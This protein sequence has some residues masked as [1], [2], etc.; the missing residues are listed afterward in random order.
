[1]DDKRV[2]EYFVV[3]GL[4]DNPVP[5]E[6]YNNDTAIKSTHKQDPIVD[7]AVIIRN[8]GEKPPKGFKCVELTPLGFPADLNHGSIRSPEVYLCYRRGRDKPPLIDIGVLYE[9]KERV[10]SG[11][12]VIHVTPG[13]RPANVNNSTSNRIYITFRRAGE[14]AA[15]DTLAVTD[16]CVILAN[17]GETPPHAY[18]QIGK[19][20][21][22]AMVGSDVYLCYKKSMAKANTLAYQPA[23]LNRYPELNYPDFPL[24]DQVSMFCLPMG[25]TIESWSSTAQHPL[26]VF[27]TFVLTDET[28]EQVY[29][30]AVTFYEEY[31]EDKLNDS[32]KEALSLKEGPTGNPYNKIPKTVHS[33]KS[34]C[35]LSRWPF[36][37]AFKKFLSYLY[38]I[39]ISGPHDVPI[40]RHIS[41][42]MHEVP[43]PSPQRPRI[44]VQLRQ[45]A[46]SLSMPEDSPLPH[47]GASF[48]TL[49]K[50][51]GP[52]DSMNV[53]LFALM[54]HKLLLHSLRPAVLTSVTEAVITMIF[55][56]K[57]QCPYIPLCPLGMSGV[58]NAP[59]PFIVGVDSRY[60]D[61]YDPPPDVTC[62]D[63]DTQTI[64]Q[65]EERKSINYKMLP[66]KPAKVL[67]NTLERLFDIVCESA[68]ATPDEVAL[69]MNMGSVDHDFKRK[70]KEIIMET[71]VQEAFLRFMAS[72]L[73]GYKHH[74]LPITAAPTVGTTDASRLFDM[75]NFLKSREK[76]NHRFFTSIMKTQTFIRFIEDRS[77]VSDNDASLAFFD[78]CAEKVD[79]NRDEPKLIELDESLRQDRTV[80][81]LPPEPTGLAEGVKYSYNGFPELNDGLF[82]QRIVPTGFKTPSKPL[83]PNSPMARR[84]KQEIRS[85]QKVA[86]KQSGTPML[87]AKCLLGHCYSLW[88]IHL[89]A[90]VKSVHS[91]TKA[92]R[93]AYHVLVRMQA[94]RLQVPDEV[95]YRVLMQ[96]CG[97]YHQ[98]V[99]AVK[100]LFEMKRHGI[101][102]NAITYGFYNKAVLESKW[103]SKETNAYQLWTKVRNLIMGVAQFKRALRRRSI[104]S[105]SESDLDGI[106]RASV[107][108]FLDDVCSDKVDSGTGSGTGSDKI[109]GATKPDAAMG[110]SPVDTV[111]KEEG[112]SIT[113]LGGASDRGYSSMTWE[114]AKHIKQTLVAAK[115]LDALPG[116]IEPTPDSAPQ[117]SL[118]TTEN[119][120][121]TEIA[122]TETASTVPDKVDAPEGESTPPVEVK[123]EKKDE[124]VFKEPKGVTPRKHRMRF[125]SGKKKSSSMDKSS[126][127]SGSKENLSAID[128]AEDWRARF[129]SIVKNGSTNGA[130]R[131]TGSTSSTGTLR[132]SLGEGVGSSA[133]LLI[134]SSQADENVFID[135]NSVKLASSL[136]IPGPDG[137][138]NLLDTDRRRHKSAEHHRSSSD[139]T[140]NNRHQSGDAVIDNDKLG[141][142]Q[143][144]KDS[145]WVNELNSN[146][147]MQKGTMLDTGGYVNADFDGRPR[148]SSSPAKLS[149]TSGGGDTQPLLTPLSP[150]EA[151]SGPECHNLDDQKTPTS[152]SVNTPETHSSIDTS[153]TVRPTEIPLSTPGESKKDG[154]V[155]SPIQMTPV[156]ENDPLG[157]FVDPLSSPTINSDPLSSNAVNDPLSSNVAVTT[158]V[159]LASSSST[160]SSTDLAADS[161]SE[162]GSHKSSPVTS[163]L[164]SPTKQHLQT[165]SELQPFGGRSR[166][167]DDIDGGPDPVTPDAD[168]SDTSKGSSF[169]WDIP[170]RLRAI[171]ET[172]DP[173][174]KRRTESEKSDTL[175]SVGSLSPAPEW[176]P[177]GQ[178]QPPPPTTESTPNTDTSVTDSPVKKYVPKSESFT[179]ALKFG[180]SK[181]TKKINELKETLQTN[182]PTRSDSLNSLSRSSDRGDNVSFDGDNV[183]LNI[184]K[185]DSLD[186]LGRGES[187][188]DPRE[189]DTD[190][191]DSFAS[192]KPAAPFGVEPS[193][194][195]SFMPLK[196]FD[197]LSRQN[198]FHSLQQSIFNVAFDVEIQSMT[199]CNS[200]NSLLYDEEI[201]AGWSAN[202][203]DLNT[204]CQFC[205]SKLVPFLHVY[206]KD[207]RH[208]NQPLKLSESMQSLHSINSLPTN[209]IG[210]NLELKRSAAHSMSNPTLALRD[211]QAL[212]NKSVTSLTS[213]DNLVNSS[214]ESKNIKQAQSDS[215]VLANS[216]N[217]KSENITNKSVVEHAKRTIDSTREESPASVTDS[218]GSREES[219]GIMIEAHSSRN[220]SPE[221]VI[222][223]EADTSIDSQVQNT[224][225][226]PAKTSTDP[227]QEA[228]KDPI[229]VAETVDQ[230]EEPVAPTA[231][232]VIEEEYLKLKEDDAV[233]EFDDGTDSKADSGG[234]DDIDSVAKVDPIRVPYLSPLVLRKEVENILE[235]EGDKCLNKADFCDEHPIIFWNLVWYFRRLEIPSHLP[236][237]II[238]A[239]S[240]NT[241]TKSV[242]KVWEKITDSKY[243]L[244]RPGWDNTRHHEEAGR[245]LYT[246]WSDTQ[247]QNTNAAL[248]TENQV[249]SKSVMQNIV[250]SIQCNDVQ[251]PI[252]VLMSE[253]RR[254][255]KHQPYNKWL[256]RSIYR[257]VLFLSLIACGKDNIDHDAFDMEYQMAYNKLK[258]NNELCR[259]QNNDRPPNPAV[260]WCR[261][262]F[263]VLEL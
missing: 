259:A 53:L 35:L 10:M 86:L 23:I 246:M 49:L 105:L 207:L 45:E 180:W 3:A 47:S 150:I 168:A 12:E 128:P 93:T 129:G 179:N 58:L 254:A 139:G 21:N 147:P 208:V 32:Q 118:L 260:M 255:L 96:L 240:T 94:S 232:D 135:S 8:A 249:F 143:F 167:L 158:T 239:K 243:V 113:S 117:V 71:A 73:K 203:S 219:L 46:L 62:I 156:T 106:S 110:T 189:P 183:S 76:A 126:I 97:H 223:T 214:L 65:P 5:L 217:K 81:I 57:W 90:Y 48:V 195:E 221:V 124:H 44:L 205:S 155:E 159:T 194:L 85:A 16:I 166:T 173:A 228:Q 202:D 213:T 187:F 248:V 37:D 185:G 247:S 66:R 18:C 114:E 144:K 55:P 206:L 22:K 196:D 152:F 87:W 120:A 131:N 193:A 141:T 79:E 138:K 175:S 91:K 74:L 220:E 238:S 216:D 177:I 241:G 253:R 67:R 237:F 40:E 99:L 132:A 263:G 176:T 212:I 42:F 7:V 258:E 181:A 70:R 170:N 199:R 184:K 108:S 252:K 39:S 127:S 125:W 17:K 52:E 2:A 160:S 174:G 80:F 188:N 229:E 82:L 262:L 161:L 92:L 43:F 261:K 101:Q 24:P 121:T 149:T 211:K 201:M 33:N 4:P 242:P 204:C 14:T 226:P 151:T 26:P 218:H 60:F 119:N 30:A 235:Q 20:L 178:Q 29:G 234:K 50:N 123:P 227:L 222:P 83:I 25:T 122:Y 157:V 153:T 98:P 9:G 142:D 19:N 148:N 95:C 233:D 15:S 59:C 140:C 100:V 257:D 162:R 172:P 84:T 133:G 69:D 63:L 231:S 11:C 64:S 165:L 77:F 28:R 103:P 136:N 230:Q 75:Q 13:G 236:G 190:S 163:T 192:G 41:H 112:T 145:D 130:T 171:S 89:P 27:S 164:S 107:D 116:G 104:A 250:A 68:P 224:D 197:N 109:D 182:T 102:P 56:L 6:E 38:R 256:F 169:I 191:M 115:T 251:T 209:R 36:F 198:S 215:N 31:P 146:E 200:C 245:P 51:L 78:E 210:L 61:L 186:Y 225:L 54:E 137:D 88:F 154:A 111:H 34:I 72:V 1:M 244:L 134:T